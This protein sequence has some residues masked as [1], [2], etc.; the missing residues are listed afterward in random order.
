MTEKLNRKGKPIHTRPNEVI[1][2][3]FFVFRR[4][5][6]AN[7]VKPGPLPFEHGTFE[8]AQT[9][10]IRLAN[11]HPGLKFIILQDLAAVQ[12]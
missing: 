5:N 1:G 8:S 9:E 12:V 3:G 4:G 11:E 2:G 7:R 10:A 6:Y